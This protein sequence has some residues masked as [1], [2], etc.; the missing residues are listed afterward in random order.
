[1]QRQ[2]QFEAAWVPA[3]ELPSLVVAAAAVQELP[4]DSAPIVA[5]HSLLELLL[6]QAVQEI[7]LLALPKVLT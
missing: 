3:L 2:A 6:A 5:K 4:D 1:M 7:S